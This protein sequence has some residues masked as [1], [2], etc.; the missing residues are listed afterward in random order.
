MKKLSYIVLLI[1]IQAGIARA[2]DSL[3][4]AHWPMDEGMDTVITDLIHGNNG[5]M[6]GLDATKAWLEG[7]GVSFDNIDGHHIEVPHAESYDFGNES[8]TVSMLVR[9]Q[10]S[11]RDTDRWIIKGTHGSPGT[12]SRFEVFRTSGNTVRFAIDNGPAD[13]KSRVEVPDEAFTTGDW[14]HVVAVRDTSGSIN[15]PNAPD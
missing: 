2:Q 11:P 9:Y 1:L 12:G 7:G 13:V 14:V 6:I 4:V 3:L 8:F 15:T 10:I 5:A